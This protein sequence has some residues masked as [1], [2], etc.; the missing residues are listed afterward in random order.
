MTDERRTPVPVDGHAGDLVSARLDGELDDATAAWVDAHLDECAPCRQAARAVEAARSW[1]RTSPSVDAAP[2][3]E[4]VIARR[5]RLVGNGLVFVGIAWFTLGLLAVT[6]AVA[7]PQVVPDVDA[8]V[9][10][11]T[12]A[13]HDELDGMRAVDQGGSHYATPVTLGDRSAPMQRRAVYDGDDLTTVVYES[14]EIAVTVFEQPGRVDWDELP[15]GTNE[16]VDGRRVWRRAGSP[17]VVVTE[18]GDLVVTLV[19][20]GVDDAT[21][22]R[23]VFATLPAPRRTST[24]DR[25]HDSCQQLMEIFALG[26]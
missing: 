5:R 16:T 2:V 9:T 6:S 23:D 7:H 14:T 12:D 11:H 25:V 26:G 17:T 19:V 22:V 10:A 1:M 4:S 18:I 20:D 24:L 21:V 3:V 13:S 15:D 8:M